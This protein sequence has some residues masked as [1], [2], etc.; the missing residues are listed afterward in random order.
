LKQRRVSLLKQVGDLA[1]EEGAGR[2]IKQLAESVRK[3]HGNTGGWWML[4]VRKTLTQRRAQLQLMMVEQLK[5]ELQP[6]IA[7]HLREKSSGESAPT[8]L[9]ADRPTQLSD[10][11]VAKLAELQKQVKVLN[12]E[13]GKL[14][15][16]PNPGETPIITQYTAE[17]ASEME[18]EVEAL[19]GKLSPRDLERVAKQLEESE[20]QATGSQMGGV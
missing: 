7:D 2:G 1:G 13:K 10:D 6:M 5:E 9:G 15:S 16:Q 12:A 17:K 11:A 3:G 8:P 20:E 18:A 19:A 4:G 14:P